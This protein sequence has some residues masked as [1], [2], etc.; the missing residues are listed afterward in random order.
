MANWRNLPY[1]VAWIF[2]DHTGYA[3]AAIVRVPLGHT[4]AELE[5]FALAGAQRLEPLSDSELVGVQIAVPL[6]NLGNAAALPAEAVNGRLGSFIFESTVP[7]DRFIVH[8]PGM[9]WEF[10]PPDDR[11][12][13]LH[14][15]QTNLDVIAFVDM[16]LGSQGLVAQSNAGNPLFKLNVAYWQDRGSGLVFGGSGGGG[17]ITWGSGGGGGITWGSG[18]GGGISW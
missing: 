18:G 1:G 13:R 16:L 3:D 12:F 11:G 14:I 8:I 5:A 4:Q 17:G 2:R 6:V 15:D 9:R 7:G 10:M